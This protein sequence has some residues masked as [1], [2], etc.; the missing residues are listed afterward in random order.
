MAVYRRG[1]VYWYEFEF[2]GA[3][4]RE[5]S[6]SRLKDVAVRAERQRRREI[7]EAANGLRPIRRLVMFPQAVEE[8][9][10]QTKAAWSRNYEA[11]QTYNLKHLHP[12]FKSKFLNEIGHE[13]IGRYQAKRQSDGASNRTINMEVSTLRMILKSFK[14]WTAIA[15]DVRML[16]E[17]ADVGKALDPDEAERLLEACFNSAQPSLYPAVV[18]YCNTGVR[19][20]ELRC[21]RWWQVNFREA[22]FQV[23]KSKTRGG[24]GRIIPLNREAMDAFTAWHERWPDA[25]PTDF[26]FPSEKLVFKGKGSAKLRVMTGYDTDFTKP[27]GSWKRAWKTA[28]RLA[29]V[30]A[31]IHDLRHHFLTEVGEAQTPEKTMKALAGHLSEKMLDRYVHARKMAK[32]RAVEALDFGK[33]DQ[34]G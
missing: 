26:I 29:G 1:K 14:L 27:V 25:K 18:I 21:A 16:E 28:L 3:R 6:H 2:Q 12:Y 9:T 23:G 34:K 11:I 5:S 13:D 17:R 7:E 24:D 22:E 15:D 33:K 31:R 30:T 19:N 8:W 20:A 4:V 32:R 10:E